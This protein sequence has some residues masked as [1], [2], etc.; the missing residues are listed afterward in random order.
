[1]R[2]SRP[3]AR[4]VAPVG[5][6]L[7]VLAAEGHAQPRAP[8]GVPLPDLT[9]GY[10]LIEGDIQVRLDRYLAYLAGL[11]AVF[12]P[13]TYW[14]G[15]TVP[16][17]FSTTG[18]AAVSVANQQAMLVAMASIEVRAGVDFRP[19]QAG[20]PDWILVQ[21]STVNNSP[22]GVQGGQQNV[23]IASWGNQFVI[24]HELYHTLGFQHEQS[25]S[26]RGTY[27]TINLANICGAAVCPAGSG[28]GQ[29]C[30]CLDGAGACIP[31]AFNFN[32]VSNADVYGDYDFDSLMHYGPA[33]FS[34]N[35]QPTISLNA[36]WNT[37]TPPIVIGQRTHFSYM[38]EIAC[39]G[40]YPFSG[41]RWLDRD[42]FGPQSGT[43]FQPWNVSFQSAL[44][45]TP[46]G[47]T[48]FF[49]YPGSYSAVGLYGVP[50]TI[51]SPL[52]TVTLGN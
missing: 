15:G 31:C 25:R 11:D 48:L 19:R 27:V 49:R 35:G 45:F 8:Q 46:G 23:N 33:D 28:P 18:S 20:D 9:P 30:L 50:R 32:I 40:I 24:A 44:A 12:G 10:V 39:R 5:L 42:Y 14:P 6:A 36:P 13:A 38:D 21:N 22:V 17:V 16:Y 2:P 51:R 4:R 43:L 47:G 34:C 37:A 1:M 41:D 3:N 7:G 29:C 52:G 26:D